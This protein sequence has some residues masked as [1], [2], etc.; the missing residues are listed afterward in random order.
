MVTI[1]GTP[2]PYSH[3]MAV[4]ISGLTDTPTVALD[5]VLPGGRVEPVRHARALAPTGGIA[6]TDDYD[7]PT[8]T[9][10]QYRV[11]QGATIVTSS[12]MTL[13]SG[14]TFWLGEPNTGLMQRIIP[15]ANAI[16]E[17]TREAPIGVH[18]VLGREDPVVVV[19]RRWWAQGEF[20]LYTLN[21][22]QR[23]A[24]GSLWAMAATLGF[25]GPAAIIGGIGRLYIAS[26]SVAERRVSARGYETCRE[27]H[28]QITQ[29][30]EPVGPATA[31]IFVR[32]QDVVDSYA[33]HQAVVDGE[34]DWLDVMTG[35][36]T[37]GSGSDVGWEW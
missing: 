1:A 15:A 20:T 10:Y 11:T 26:A 13:P 14:N 19:E 16:P 18:R 37:R 32:W 33:T 3:R 31:P 30:A 21:D 24:M 7:V 6:V 22:S 36:P 2:D 9:P 12:D 29:V 5:R 28:A 25:Y 23:D 17:W 34:H 8:D 35:V 4:V 27:W